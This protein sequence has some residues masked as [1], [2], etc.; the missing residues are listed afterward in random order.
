MSFFRI[1]VDHAEWNANIHAALLR[2]FPE[3][4]ARTL[5]VHAG[6]AGMRQLQNLRKDFTLRNE[7]TEGSL[8]IGKGAGSEG[9]YW[10]ASPTVPIQRMN[11]VVGSK[12]PYLP[13]QETGGVA[14]AKGKSLAMP[15]LAGRGGDEKR[16]IPQFFRFRSMGQLGGTR[17]KY[18]TR[19]RRIRSKGFFILGP[20][21]RLKEPAIFFREPGGGG[22][23]LMKIRLIGRKSQRVRATHWHTEAVRHYGT[24][25][26]FNETY[27]RVAKLH[28]GMR[29]LAAT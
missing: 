16:P 27:A 19:G 15:T 28:A 21:P 22:A 9:L 3:I 6:L 5:N 20:G 18:T 14:Q 4:I 8:H 29:K 11:A 13:L 7:Y 12:S 24:W 23:R 26:G 1:M 10:P 17:Q 25:K 2:G